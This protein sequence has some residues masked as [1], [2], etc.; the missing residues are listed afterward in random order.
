M[1]SPHFPRPTSFSTLAG[2]TL[3]FALLC[4]S[5]ASLAGRLAVLDFEL[6]DTTLDPGGAEQV[7][8]TRQLAPLLR[9][10]LASR[11]VELLEIP[12]PAAARSNHGVG[13][14]F[15]RP[16][17]AAAL[18]RMG[19][20]EAIAVCRHDRPTPLFSYLRVRLVDA[21]RAKVIEDFT[22]EIKGQFDVTA[23]HGTARLAEG[24]AGRLGGS[25]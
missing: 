10:A 16:Q 7:E 17:L 14:L 25:N 22:V 19:G 15:D 6:V 8:R 2:F 3:A 11:G 24:I 1:S 13:Y 21:D 23:R 18:A 20:A 4:I 9:E 5:P 12:G